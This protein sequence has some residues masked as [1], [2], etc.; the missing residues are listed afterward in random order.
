MESGLA[1]RRACA[2]KGRDNAHHSTF[3]KMSMKVFQP[4]G[5]EGGKIPLSN[6]GNASKDNAGDPEL[7]RIPKVLA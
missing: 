5:F 1:T 2:G 4:A 7:Y 3:S 6:P